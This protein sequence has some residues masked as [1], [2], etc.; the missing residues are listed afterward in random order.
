MLQ[1]IYMWSDDQQEWVHIL[2]AANRAIAE[3]TVTA[4]ESVSTK[5]F[6]IRHK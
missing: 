3:V 4:L 2:D 6:E 5:R 1:S